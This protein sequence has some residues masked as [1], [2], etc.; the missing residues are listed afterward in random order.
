MAAARAVWMRIQRSI[1]SFE[2]TLAYG[3]ADLMPQR[4]VVV[5]SY[6]KQI[7]ETEWIVWA[8]ATASAPAATQAS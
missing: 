7:G 8:C 3:R 4:P 5:S 6:K 1:Y 2:M